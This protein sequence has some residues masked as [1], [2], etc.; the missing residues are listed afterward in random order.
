MGPRP[1]RNVRP[2]FFNDPEAS[3]GTDISVCAF[4][5]RL[6]SESQKVQ[7][8]ETLACQE[9]NSDVYKALPIYLRNDGSC[10]ALGNGGI[11][12]KNYNLT[13][14]PLQATLGQFVF[15]K[16][17]HEAAGKAGQSSNGPNSLYADHAVVIYNETI[18]DPSYGITASIDPV[19]PDQPAGQSFVYS[20]GYKEQAIAGTVILI[21]LPDGNNT[22]ITRE[23]NGGT[24]EIRFSKQ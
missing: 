21:S 8:K 4:L 2:T 10:R 15:N 18:Y 11:L 17:H 16:L 24:Y 23:Q 5:N 13:N 12:V 3:G 6:L 9:I 1:D 19:P 20:Q 22:A 14:H 7:F